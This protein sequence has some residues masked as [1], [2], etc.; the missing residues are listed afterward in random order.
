MVFT[1]DDISGCTPHF[2][3]HAYA[4]WDGANW[5]VQ[6]ASN[7]CPKL[8]KSAQ[9]AFPMHLGGVRYKLYYGDPSITTGKVSGTT[10]FLGPKK[11]IY[12]DGA[13]SASISTVDF[14][15][16]ESQ[17][18]ARDVVFLWPNGDQ[19][20]DTVEGYIDDYHFL[21]PTGS[22]DLQVLYMGITDGTHIKFGAS[23]VLLNP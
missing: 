23:A 10:G 22:L 2:M 1:V 15:D 7:G 19:L 5:V 6:Y 17:T 12:A 3:N 8:F 11:I 18:L 4:V 20:D 13:L 21:A 9:A 16:W 14:E